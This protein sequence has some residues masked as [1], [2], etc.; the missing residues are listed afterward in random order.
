MLT[1]WIVG[2]VVIGATPPAAGGGLAAAAASSGRPRECAAGVGA[3]AGRGPTVW[4]AARLPGL[5]RYCDLLAKAQAEL[6]ASPTSAR[7]AAES[8]AALLPGRAA[9]AAM[10]ARAALATGDLD[11]AARGFEAARAID[12]RSIED[13]PTMHDLAQ[14]LRRTGKGPEAIA[15]YRTLVPRIDLLASAERR[16]V[17]LL[18]AAHAAMAIDDDF[19]GREGARRGHLEEAVA[20]LRE[21]R[22]R[23]PTIWTGDVL[24]GLA[25]ALD[26]AGDRAASDA[27][28]AEAHRTGRAPRAD[29]PRY[30]ARADDAIA[31]TAIAAEGDDRAGAARSWEAWLATPAG[32]GP[33]AAAAQARLEALKKPLAAARPAASTKAR[34]AGSKPR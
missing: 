23:P 16:V 1:A 27:V 10:I 24:F 32:R 17:V 20:Y 6:A 2:L 3:A 31:L 5:E 14:T 13:P 21:A 12:P 4:Q 34:A 28:L 8:A 26:R 11:E 19:A 25:I 18:E 29:A 33:W 9:P 22:L 15:V 30:L 7:A